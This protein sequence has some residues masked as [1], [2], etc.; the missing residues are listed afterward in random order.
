M[1]G[2]D[3]RSAPKG[4]KS[5]K[6]RKVDVTKTDEVVRARVDCR[7]AERRVYIGVRGGRYVRRGN[8]TYVLLSKLPPP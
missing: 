5:S 6:H 8:G 7:S 3:K 2:S 1:N 4:P